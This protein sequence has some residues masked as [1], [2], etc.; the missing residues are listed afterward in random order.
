M[1]CY[2]FYFY[3]FSFCF[4][5]NVNL[6]KFVVILRFSFSDKLNWIDFIYLTMQHLQYLYIFK[7]HF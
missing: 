3:I 6:N 4:N 1:Y 2:R 7:I 5:L